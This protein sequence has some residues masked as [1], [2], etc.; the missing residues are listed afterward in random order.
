MLTHTLGFARIGI[1][2]EL[3]KAQE[4]YWRGE[5]TEE[6]LDLVAAELRL[7]H[8]RL[9]SQEGIDL[10]PAGDFSLYDHMLDMCALVG[11][12]PE[13]FGFKG[14]QVSTEMYF[15]MARG[16]ASAPAMEMTKW[17]DTNYHYI[18]PEF[19]EGMKFSISSMKIFDDVLQAK[20]AGFKVKAVMP[21]PVTFMYLGKEYGEDFS[22]WELF[23]DLVEVYCQILKK[24]SSDCAWIELDEPVL[25][26]KLTLDVREQFLSAYKKIREA[27][28]CK[29]MLA[30]YFGSI[31]G[32]ENLVSGLPV[33]ALHIDLFRAPKL[34]SSIIDKIPDTMSLSL[35][36]VNGRNIWRVDA[37]KA[38]GVIEE[39]RRKIGVERIMLAPSCSLLHVPIDLNEEEKLDLE[40]MEWMAFGR[41]KCAELRML[42]DVFLGVS[43]DVLLD[44][45]SEAWQRRR[46]S[47]LVH[48]KKVSDRV[49]QITSGMLHRKTRHTMRKQVQQEIL[50]LPVLP[51]TTIGS[52]PQTPQIRKTRL[53]FR[54]GNINQQQYREKMQGFIAEAVKWQEEIDLDVLVH[55]EPERN[56]MV[57]Y[58]GEQL[59]GFCF[60]ENGWVQSYGSRCVKPPIIYGDVYRTSAMTVDWIS[61]AQSI[62][63]KPMKGMLTG[64]VTILC[65]SFV[66][67]DQ[68]RQDTCRQ[69]A[70]AIRDEVVDLETAG[71]K[72]IQIDEAALREGLP[73]N[74]D[75][76]NDYLQW[77][78]E[79]FGIASSGV[80][81]STQ[82]H[83]HMCYS[84]FNEIAEW[85][86]R[87][88]ADVISIEA[89]R[90][91]M[92]LLEVFRDFE[93]PNDIGPGVYDIHSP[94]VPS[95]DEIAALL[96]KALE[97][98]PYDRLWVNP[99]CGLK[100]RG[101]P[102]AVE[103][104]KNMMAAALLVRSEVNAKH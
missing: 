7:R 11:A 79:C 2:R 4:G 64:P 5:V 67:D 94:R 33:D 99:D 53:D 25:A 88:D 12:V 42:A 87:M 49:R 57:E 65:W 82:I 15:S 41:Q 56:D 74:R 40:I 26:Y 59:E 14:G 21:G 84:E 46:S 78:V 77:A 100:T 22:R 23:D 37:D 45:N 75:E 51:T 76:W 10:I 13:R 102:E 90:S 66:R 86:A 44:A 50:R 43:E 31:N 32:N 81:D 35:G 89:S 54:R 71:I 52:F 36:V 30:T 60:T 16:N 17:F 19:T 20:V 83:T 3:K 18:V 70:L 95:K 93:Y 62:T 27:V 104:L 1:N 96:R 69:L 103:S 68:P 98:V 48:N 39:A 61:Y 9:Q 97:V 85:I 6:E 63:R 58:F 28:G 47:N 101:W 29:L 38:L 24:L 80:K 92:E 73:L 34:M 8:W 72:I 55:G 91:K